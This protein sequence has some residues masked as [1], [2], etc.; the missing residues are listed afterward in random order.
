MD[1]LLVF[2]LKQRS[3]YYACLNC[4]CYFSIIFQGILRKRHLIEKNVS[5]CELS[6]TIYYN[7]PCYCIFTFF[8]ML[9]RMMW[10]LF[11]RVYELWCVFVL[12]IYAI[13]WLKVLLN[14]AV[15]CF[16][17]TSLL[18][19]MFW[20]VNI[21]RDSWISLKFGYPIN[22]FMWFQQ[23]CAIAP[24]VW[25]FNIVLVHYVIFATMNPDSIITFRLTLGAL[26]N[27]KIY[28]GF[29]M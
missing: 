23:V 19:K 28:L 7:S 6:G 8:L 9:P 24:W 3:V 18:L 14:A 15:L 10:K 25:F 16:L 1:F 12:Y 29:H 4:A 17:T 20:L 21:C 13:T 5:I 27:D 22:R 2:L 11:T 26:K